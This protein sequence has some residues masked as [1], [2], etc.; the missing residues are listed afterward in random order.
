MQSDVW[1]IIWVSSSTQYNPFHPGDLLYINEF[2]KEKGQTY[3]V[4][5]LV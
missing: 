4:P 1:D 5:L 3:L 2:Q